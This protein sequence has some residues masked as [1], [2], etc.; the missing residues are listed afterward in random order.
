MSKPTRTTRLRCEYLEAR[1]VPAFLT[2]VAT[3][4]DLNVTG[5]F[6]GD[7]KADTVEFVQATNVVRVRLGNGDGTFQ[8]ARDTAVSGTASGIST[9]ADVNGDGRTD[10]LVRWTTGE[11][12]VLLGNPDGSLTQRP[13]S[14]TLPRV[15]AYDGTRTRL[16]TQSLR[17][18]RVGDVTG[19]GKPDVVVFGFTGYSSHGVP[20]N[21]GNYVNI[22]AGNGQGGFASPS[23]PAVT[24]GG[25]G[26][27]GGTF[28]QT[29][30]LADFTGDGRTDILYAVN[31]RGAAG[32]SSRLLI[33][34]PNG[35]FRSV[36]VPTATNST[37][38]VADLNGDGKADV[39]NYTPGSNVVRVALS[40]GDGAFAAPSTVDVGVGIGT[41]SLA[42]LNGDGKADLV[43]SNSQTVGADSMS[44][45]LG[46]GD[47]AFQS[48]RTFAVGAELISIALADFDGDG[49]LDLA[50]REWNGAAY[51]T[52]ILF[53]DGVW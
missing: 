48:A 49:R 39:V 44:V 25:F 33:N 17:Q 43:V 21:T 30:H 35:T 53:N 36:N 42:D 3:D 50:R 41:V 6:N 8:P 14:L 40:Q 22:F 28:T 38:R 45:Y 9:I 12:V 47:G 19:D 23:A 24:M 29:A 52:S 34:E 10:A 26:N 27:R 13:G 51:Q 5:D 31:T 1:D 18:V 46:N 11:F 4:A 2:P 20:V 37:V 16:Q 32:P 15:S 7:R